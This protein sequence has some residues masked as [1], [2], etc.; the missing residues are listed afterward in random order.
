V[1]GFVNT[2]FTSLVSKAITA[3][4]AGVLV[5]TGR[6]ASELDS[7]SPAASS[8]RLL[9]RLTVDGTQAGAESETSL[10]DSAAAC[11]EGRTMALAVAVPVTAGSH[12]VALE[13][14]KSTTTG[15]TG[16][17]YVGNGSFT[18][19]F[20]PFGNDGAQGVLS[21]SHVASTQSAPNH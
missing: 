7:T 11:K 13:I 19:I 2:T 5:I 1:T 17:A 15:G 20:V 3:P 8:L 10:S 9:G 12:T 16:K 21:T 18:T 4:A 14:A 6:V